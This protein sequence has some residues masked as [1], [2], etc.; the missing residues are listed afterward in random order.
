M[1]L[2]CAH[3]GSRRKLRT[4]GNH[5]PV[6][7]TFMP[8]WRGEG[9]VIPGCRHANASLPLPRNLIGRIS[10]MAA[11]SVL[12]L[13]LPAALLL[14][15]LWYRADA[16]D[17]LKRDPPKSG[18]GRPAWR[19]RLKFSRNTLSAPEKGPPGS[20]GRRSPGIGAGFTAMA[21]SRHRLPAGVCEARS[22]W[23]VLQQRASRLVR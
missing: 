7:S 10:G 4:P 21:R 1:S 6:S 17:E 14:H 12:P 5:G 13:P 20:A 23:H 2:N 18:G 16:L 8:V 15:L 11:S 22:Y 19:G 9:A 3:G